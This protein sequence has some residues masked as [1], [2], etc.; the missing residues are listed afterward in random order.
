MEEHSI[1][2][3]IQRLISLTPEE[4]Q[5]I[6]NLV[7]TRKISKKEFLLKSDEICRHLVYIKKGCIKTYRF[8]QNGLEHII[9]F[10]LEDWWAVDLKSFVTQTGARFFIQAIENCE[11]DYISRDNFYQ[12]LDQL[13]KLEKWFR[14][15]LQNALI[16]TEDRVERELSL[17]AEERYHQFIQKYPTLE[18]RISQRQIASYLGITPEFLSKLRSDIL[19]SKKP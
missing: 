18:R 3:H 15:L 9:F 12:L 8:D 4:T 2:G 19:K 17:S 16:S 10:S 13:P 1:I 6:K 7:R 11:I 14:V 5:H